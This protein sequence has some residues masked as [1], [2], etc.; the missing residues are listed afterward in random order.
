MTR[1]ALYD[2]TGGPEV[3]RIGTVEDAQPGPGEVVLR[4]RAAGLNPIDSKIRTGFVPL[5]APFPRR[6]GSDVAGTVEAVGDSAVYWDGTPIVVGDEVFG[7]GEGSI[8]E[9]T[10]AT[11]DG[12]AKRADSVPLEV[13]GGLWIAGLT[14]VSCLVTVPVGE[15]DVVLVGGAS[16]A[17]GI[18]AAQLAA[19]AGAHVIGTAS[20]RNH[21]FLRS[22]GVEPVT[23]GGGLTARVRELGTVTAVMD[24]HGREVLDAGVEL[25]VPVDR[26]VAIAAYA[27]LEELGVHN[28]ERDA[29]TAENLAKLG[30]RI[31]DGTLVLPV[32]DVYSLDDVVAAFT[33]LEGSHVPGKIVVTP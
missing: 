31:A 19:A 21:E 22:I 17:V 11:A 29:R 1:A 10:I 15:G 18:V 13:A 26:M 20:E 24:C 33:A 6:V 5:N 30:D 9:R 7:R 2:Q 4:V 32:A 23:Y 25:G 14:A 3:L 28:V 16:G 12:I 27:A 8:A